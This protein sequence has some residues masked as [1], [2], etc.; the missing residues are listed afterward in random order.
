MGGA[1]EL[2]RPNVGTV[3]GLVGGLASAGVVVA[4]APRWTG[5]ILLVGAG[6]AVLLHAA[7]AARRRVGDSPRVR[8]L[9]ATLAMLGV[10]GLVLAVV[11][12]LAR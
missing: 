4:G 8:V 10:L 2:L 9:V 7:E 1:R 6:Q 3:L 11:V 5:V 12:R